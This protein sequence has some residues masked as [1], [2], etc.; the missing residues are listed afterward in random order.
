MD[1]GPFIANLTLFYYEYKYLD[2]LY[3]IYYFS[4]KRLNNSFRLIDDITSINS[5]GVFQEHFKS[6][7]PDSLVLNKENV[8]DNSAHVIDLNINIVNQHCIVGV[9]DKR[10]DF[11]FDIVQYMSKCSNMSV[12]TLNGIFG[13]QLI[14]FSRICNNNFD[15]FKNRV[16]I[17]LSEFIKLGFNR[18]ILLNKYRHFVQK[19]NL[20][21]KF[22]GISEL[23]YLFKERRN[24]DTLS[25][26]D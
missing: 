22:K 11:P 17:M 1:P 4:A 20:R 21:N 2:R 10:D 7:Y 15:S 24:S 14:R 23:E 5:D 25:Y 6:I 16:E 26:P 3:K 12:D 13:S 8:D 19:Y 18:N 9:Y